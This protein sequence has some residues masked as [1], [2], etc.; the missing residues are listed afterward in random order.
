MTASFLKGSWRWIKP[1]LLNVLN[2]PD[3][4]ISVE[5]W[6]ASY[7]TPL[8]SPKR[9]LAG[10]SAC[11]TPKISKNCS[12]MSFSP[13]CASPLVTYETEYRLSVS[14][15]I[16]RHLSQICGREEKLLLLQEL[17]AFRQGWQVRLDE[18]FF[19][20][21]NDPLDEYHYVFNHRSPFLPS[22]L[23]CLVF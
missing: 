23:G 9:T 21:V 6:V 11:F 4:E 12:S 10:V 22:R 16:W 3:F 15:K 2:W 18:D 8:A 1:K 19:D 17:C 7:S 20:V 5:A 13:I 14:V